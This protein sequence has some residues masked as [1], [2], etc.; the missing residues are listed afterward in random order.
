MVSS[1]QNDMVEVEKAYGKGN[2]ADQNFHMG[3][4]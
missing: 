4:D 1:S 3:R 2:K